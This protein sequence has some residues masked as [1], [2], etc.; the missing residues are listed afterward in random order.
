MSPLF[1]T[2]L[3]GLFILGGTV[4]GVYTTNNK[5]FVE[6]SIGGAFG[7]V[8]SL[9]VLELVPEAYEHLKLS[10]N[11]RTV[12]ML[13]ITIAIGFLIMNILDKFIP[14]HEHESKHEHRHKD[15][16]CHD[17]HLGHVGILATLA[18]LLHNFFQ[19]L[20]KNG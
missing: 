11:W 3:V 10:T 12:A 17:E 14:H 8:I 7:V 1:L 15:D 5:K 9:I 16:K 13:I 19:H 20:I 18:L 4:I 6:F 2:L